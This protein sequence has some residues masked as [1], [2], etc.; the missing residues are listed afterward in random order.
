M[1][2]IKSSFYLL[3]AGQLF[4]LSVVESDEWRAATSVLY[5]IF[6]MVP[7]FFNFRSPSII[8]II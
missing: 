1:P 8:L 3:P 5:R 6:Y 4:P 2:A 7:I